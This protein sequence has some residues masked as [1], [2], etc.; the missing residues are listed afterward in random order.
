VPLTLP[1]RSGDTDLGIDG[2]WTSTSS[3]EV[4]GSAVVVR[5]ERCFLLAL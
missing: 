5:L 3:V 1:S 4:L 2:G